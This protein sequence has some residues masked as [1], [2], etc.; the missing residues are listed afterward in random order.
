M[1]QIRRL[2]ESLSLRQRI[3]LGVAVLAVLGG[4]AMLVRYQSEHDFVVLFSG[5]AP[6]DAAAV[7]NRIKEKNAEYRLSEN[8]SAVLV[9]T[10]LLNEMRLELAAAG[11]P[12]SGRIGFELFDR[13]NFGVT[14]F[15]EQ[16]NYHRALEGEIERTIRSI[17][18]IEQARV[19]ITPPK[20]SVFEDLRRSAKAS[21]LVKLRPLQKLAPNNVKAI[22]HLVAS[23]VE[24]LAPEAVSVLDIHG[25]LLTR[26][27]G[28]ENADEGLNQPLL[29]Y[30]R[31]ME[32][33]LLAKVNAT[34]EPLLG[35]DRFRAAVSVECD[36]S[37]T[38]QSEETF[39]PDA[40]VMTTSQRSEE[41][42]VAQTAQGV[43]GVASN[44]PR[45]TSRPGGGGQDLNRRTENLNFQTSRLVKKTRMPQGNVRRVS[46]SVLLDHIVRWE[47]TGPQAKRVVEAPSAS[48]LKAT[49][50][51]VAG[52]VGSQP[53]RGDLVVVE[54]LPF[55]TTVSWQAPEAKPAPAA[56]W[57]W[58]KNPYLVAGLAG[59]LLIMVLVAIVSRFMRRRTVVRK[60]TKV[61]LENQAAVEGKTAA[62]EPA[63]TRGAAIEGTAYEDGPATPSG[64]GLEKQLAAQLAEK[65]KLDPSQEQALLESL[66][67]NVKIPS[68]SSKRT[69][70]LA[71][72]LAETAKSNPDAVAQIIRGW[73]SDGEDSRF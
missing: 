18:E 45:P 73:I 68:T 54:S 31:N 5:L 23:A 69:E 1:D 58:L 72:H 29:L 35:P 47:G 22:T 55:E 6:E 52:A 53:E 40:S 41:T 38:E 30:K 20:D 56:K 33:D 57:D 4:I 65:L 9:R 66:T 11:M 37:Q 3:S 70:L 32:R 2:W 62:G 48:R 27:P 51:I 34:L 43:P 16:V 44:L 24:G 13:N 7:M 46:V 36:L 60:K 12:K 42:A 50:D 8:G 15:T 64:P 63:S 28:S 26:P 71:R 39:D 49:R 10:K 61:V 19:H 14:E 17:A 25:V 21:V 59:A 67:A